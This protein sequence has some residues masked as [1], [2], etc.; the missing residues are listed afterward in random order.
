MTSGASRGEEPGASI[1]A[2]EGERLFWQLAESLRS[3]QGVTRSTMMGLPCLRI[4]GGFFASLDR[5]NGALLI[6]L[7]QAE[8]DQ[9]VSAGKAEAFAPAG[10]RF[11]EWAAIPPDKSGTWQRLLDEALDYV[12]GLDSKSRK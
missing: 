10:R 8:V 9:M 2:A 4:N 7:P 12:S 5:R 3:I 6:K 1:D 11:R